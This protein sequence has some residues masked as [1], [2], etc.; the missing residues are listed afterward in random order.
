[1]CRLLDL[2]NQLSDFLFDEQPRVEVREETLH[3]GHELAVLDL[4]HDD[5]LAALFVRLAA[6]SFKCSLDRIG[7]VPGG[8]LTWTEL[9]RRSAPVGE[10]NRDAKRRR[11]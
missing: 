5:Q 4:A 7:R 2:R 10:L 9:H 6:M 8:E 3:A 11:A 1:M